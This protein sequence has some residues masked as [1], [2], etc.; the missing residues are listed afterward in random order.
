MGTIIIWV[1]LFNTR[2]KQTDLSLWFLILILTHLSPTYKIT[3]NRTFRFLATLVHCSETIFQ[4]RRFTHWKDSSLKFIDL[5]FFPISYSFIHN[6]SCLPHLDCLLPKIITAYTLILIVTLNL[7][8]VKN[9][10]K[11]SNLQVSLTLQQID[12]LNFTHTKQKEVV[13][14]KTNF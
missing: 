7:Q 13:N 14:K 4:H 10:R 8:S 3:L 6:P 1:Y 11:L 2:K 5:L 9:L 12:C